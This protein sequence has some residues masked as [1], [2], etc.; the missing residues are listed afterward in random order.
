LFFFIIDLQCSSRIAKLLDYRTTGM[1]KI[2]T[3]WNT[4]TLFYICI[5][6]SSHR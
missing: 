6:F 3:G 1:S 4:A 5:K 2:L